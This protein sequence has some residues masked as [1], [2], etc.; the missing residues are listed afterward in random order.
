MTAPAEPRYHMVTEGDSLSRISMRYYGMP[1]RWQEI[2]QANRDMLQGSNAL[3]VGMQLR[4][5]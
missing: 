2:F 1:N 4:I 3:R 5:P